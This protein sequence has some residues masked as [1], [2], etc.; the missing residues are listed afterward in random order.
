MSGDFEREEKSSFPVAF[1]I[2]IVVVL[3]LFAGLILV[4]RMTRS[5]APAAQPLPSAPRN[6]PPQPEFISS[7][8][9]W[10]KPQTT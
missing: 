9:R 5:K 10:P 4:T 1:A 6:K 8:R 3:V 2:G 7:S